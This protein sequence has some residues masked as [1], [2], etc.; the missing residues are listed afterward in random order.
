ML[1]KPTT[2]PG[3]GSANRRGVRV[4]KFQLHKWYLDC[5]SPQGDVF[6]G[7]AA[8]LAY[9]PLRLDYGARI[10]LGPSND[11]AV[12]KQSLSFGTLEVGDAAVRWVN[13]ALGVDGS[14]SRGTPI[15]KT[16][17]LDGECGRIDW[18]CL[19][20]DSTVDVEV[21]GIRMTGQ[22][23]AEQI[24]M[25]VH[26]WRVPFDK[27]RWGR[28]AGDDGGSSVVWIDLSGD[29][30][31]N[32][33][34]VDGREIGQGIV[35]RDGVRG[36]GIVLEFKESELIRR[37]NVATSLLGNFALLTR[38]LPRRLGS[39]HEEKLVT[40]CALDARGLTS[41]GTSI[42]EVVTWH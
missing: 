35:D 16:T 2:R 31:R 26:P 6:I 3:T 38:L 17:I 23:Y 14:W 27:L 9:G 34:W 5:V 7:Y 13:H 20:S 29:V 15:E 33:I 39:I 40:R 19:G 32:W 24:S 10:S 4:P 22:G 28:Y 18:E 1:G 42:N 36:D 41:T 12:Q 8:R 11:A 25:T 37:D 21:D 30:R